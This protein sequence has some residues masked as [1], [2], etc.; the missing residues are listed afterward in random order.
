[1]KDQFDVD[2]REKHERRLSIFSEDSESS[3]SQM[4]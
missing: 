2:M 4:E 1:M 3:D